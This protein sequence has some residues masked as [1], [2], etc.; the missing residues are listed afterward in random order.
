MYKKEEFNIIFNKIIS[1]TKIITQKISKHIICSNDH[2]NNKDD[3]KYCAFH[4][5]GIDIIIDEY[6][7]VKII[8]INGA[9]SI[10][11]R[12]KNFPQSQCMNYNIL[13]NELL[14][15]CVDLIIPPLQQVNYSAEQI[16]NYGYYKDSNK[17]E[18]LFNKKFI[19]VH[20]C[21]V[22]NPSNI[23][24]ISKQVSIKYPFILNGFFNKQ[25]SKY[26][27]RIKNPH[28]ANIDVFYGLRDLYVN[29]FTSDKYYNELVEYNNCI[30]S[31]KVKIL[32]KIQGVTYYLAN[33]ERLY[34]KLLQNYKKE[35]LFYHPKSI[36]IKITNENK[37]CS[38]ESIYNIKLIED[39]IKNNNIKLL[40]I[41]PTNGSQGKGIKII[42]NNILSIDKEVYKENIFIENNINDTVETSIIYEVNTKKNK[43]NILSKIYSKILKNK[44]KT[45]KIENKSSSL[46]SEEHTNENIESVDKDIFSFEH[47]FPE[48]DINLSDNLSNIKN[49]LILDPYNILNEMNEIKKEFNYDSFILSTYIDNPKLYKKNNDTIGR[50][51]NI[52]FYVL[53]FLEN[54]ILNVYLLNKQLIYYTVLEYNIKNIPTLFENI[55]KSDIIKMYSLTNLQII[56]NI[57]EKYNLNLDIIDYLDLLEDLDYD[58]LLIKNIEKQFLN[59]CNHTINATKN[60]FR[61]I[62]RMVKNNACFNL[63]AYD[64]LLDDNN[65]LHLIEIN[66]GADLVGLHRIV[67][68][69]TIT[70]IFEE[71]FDICIDGKI[72]NFKYFTK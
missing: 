60:E 27:K 38:P 3:N 45:E 65:I 53:L 68:D 13:M 22:E 17:K 16:D 69:K 29:K 35:E 40:I 2:Y 36:I 50:K 14:K 55:E 5:Y 52:R 19:K 51:F 56:T 59:I 15:I 63:I 57:N 12:V 47:I 10:S 25:R 41:K 42:G 49:N 70:E 24:Y 6:H 18:L 33:K 11:D 64:T 32:N 23:F 39:F 37:R 72:N 21:Y 31:R 34:I 71:L 67:G 48:N 46:F 9:P 1:Y 26:Y 4:L 20:E 43:K 61:G 54:D 8:E 58:K 28:Y 62:N 44:N 66:R 30:C 7:N